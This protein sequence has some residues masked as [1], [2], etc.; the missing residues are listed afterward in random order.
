MDEICDCTL[1]LLRYEIEILLCWKKAFLY[2][3]VLHELKSLAFLQPK[4][5]SSPSCL[6]WA[7]KQPFQSNKNILFCR[8][9]SNCTLKVICFYKPKS[10]LFSESLANCPQKP[11]FCTNLKLSFC[12]SPSS[13]FSKISH[14]YNQ[15]LSI[16]TSLSLSPFQATLCC[17]PSPIRTQP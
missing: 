9:F 14:F 1:V 3:L 15:R 4:S 17:P 8:N 7:E 16:W 5:I 6:A 10:I 12:T 2:R 13:L 11:H